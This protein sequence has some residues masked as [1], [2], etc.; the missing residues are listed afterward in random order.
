MDIVSVAFR[1]G[2]FGDLFL[3]F[4]ANNTFFD[5]GLREYFAQHNGPEA[6]FIAGGMMAFFMIIY[7]LTGLPL[8]WQYLAVYGVIL[9]LLF[10]T[11]NIFPSLKGYYSSLNHFWSGL[12]QAVSMVLILVAYS[13]TVFV[14]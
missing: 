1:G 8:K 4:L 2:F 6:L 12:W 13:V 10:R 7:N 3:Q 11:F 14:K 9:D 5:Y